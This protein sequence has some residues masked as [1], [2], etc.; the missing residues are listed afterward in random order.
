VTAR[1]P[2]DAELD[3]AVGDE[4]DDAMRVGDGERDTEVRI[5]PG[6]LAEQDGHDRAPGSRRGAELEA[7]GDAL[8]L[9]QLVEK[10][11]FGREDALSVPVEPLP[12]LGRLDAAARSVDELDAEAL[13]EARICRLTAGCVTPSRSAACEKLFFSITAQNAAS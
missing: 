6:E 10:Q 3:G 12:G 4:L 5:R 9:S 11:L 13:L 2:D 7:S 8:A 1:E